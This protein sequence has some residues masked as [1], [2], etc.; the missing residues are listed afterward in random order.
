MNKGKSFKKINIKKVYWDQLAK[1]IGISL[2]PQNKV[3]A[4]KYLTWINKW[5]FNITK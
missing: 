1:K 3:A 5:F 2:D 4:A